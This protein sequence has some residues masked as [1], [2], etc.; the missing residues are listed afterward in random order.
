[1]SKVKAILIAAVKDDDGDVIEAG[2]YVD[3]D[4]NKVAVITEGSGKTVERWIKAE[5]TDDELATIR[6]G[7][8]HV[9]ARKIC[10]AIKGVDKMVKDLLANADTRL[11]DDE[12]LTL[13]QFISGT[14]VY[15][16]DMLEGAEAEEA[17]L[18]F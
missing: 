10:K 6:S 16:T 9:K 18:P 4:D 15:A 2:H 7:K 1:M 13:S 3:A 17:S 5:L 8:G 14:A 11:N 12:R